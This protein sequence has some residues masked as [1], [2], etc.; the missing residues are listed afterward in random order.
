MFWDYQVITSSIDK[1]LDQPADAVNLQD[2]LDE[3]D[4]IQEC[5]TQNNRLIDYLVQPHIMKE[6]IGHIIKLPKDDNFRNAYVVSELLSGDF[7]RI[8]EK[9]VEK[10]H[11]NLLYSFLFSSETN[12]ELTLNPILAS[13]FSRIIMTLTMRKPAELIKHLKSRK[14]FKDDFFHH[15]DSTSITDVLYH[16]IADCGEQRSDAIRW[17]EDINLIDGLVQQLLMTKSIYIQMNIVNLLCEFLRLAFDQHH[18]LDDG[19]QDNTSTSLSISTT[20]HIPSTLNENREGI[21]SV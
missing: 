10:E 7:Q 5:L 2:F 11:F 4:L 14:T 8:Q 3:N 1:L 16:L 15:L 13:Y 21:Y 9:L 6:L 20:Q 17:Y 19:I 12:D 18:A